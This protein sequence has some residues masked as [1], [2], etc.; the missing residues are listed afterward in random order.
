MKVTDNG[1]GF[2]YAMK[3]SGNG[4]ANMRKRAEGLNAIFSINSELNQGTRI[5]L[6]MPIA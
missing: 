4:L 5:Q 6:I 1:K 2:D 3:A